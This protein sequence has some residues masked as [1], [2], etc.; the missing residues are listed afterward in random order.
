MGI[1]V[2]E[3]DNQTT[4]L[5]RGES[6]GR[7]SIYYSNQGEGYKGLG[8]GGGF[9][10]IKR[11][12]YTTLWRENWHNWVEV[13]LSKTTWSFITLVIRSTSVLVINT[14]KPG[15]GVEWELPEREDNSEFW[16]GGLKMAT[17]N[18][19]LRVWEKQMNFSRGH[20]GSEINTIMI[21][22]CMVLYNTK[23]SH[24]HYFT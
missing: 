12:M 9:K 2:W 18:V 6:I 10:I 1:W 5:N 20:H 15:V 13:W 4:T 22:I 23:C 7:Q 17:W 3:S 19:G 21:S 11:S 16:H 14:I 8:L 24:I